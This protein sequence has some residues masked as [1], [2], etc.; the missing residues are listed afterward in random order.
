MEITKEQ[1]E[2][3][4]IWQQDPM[5]RWYFNQIDGERKEI[6]E[7]M[8]QGGTIDN[9]NVYYTA[10]ETA[11]HYGYVSALDFCTTFEMEVDDES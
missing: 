4:E 2:N 9:T 11:K 5:T 7:H 6:Q 1:R 10:Q 3:L 8:G